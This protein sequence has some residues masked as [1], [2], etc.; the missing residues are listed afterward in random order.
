MVKFCENA[1]PAGNPN[2]FGCGSECVRVRGQKKQGFDCGLKA[3]CA[4][5]RCALIKNQIFKFVKT[6]RR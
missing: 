6:A 4:L 1:G 3:A 5:I 2:P